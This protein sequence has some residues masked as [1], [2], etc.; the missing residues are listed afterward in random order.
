MSLWQSIRNQVPADVFVPVDDTTV[1]HALATEIARVAVSVSGA[2]LTLIVDAATAEEVAQIEAVSSNA[3]SVY[4]FGEPPAAWKSLAQI[5]TLAPSAGLAAGD[6]FL[7]M[8]SSR[9]SQALLGEEQIVAAETPLNGG[10]TGQRPHVHAIAEAILAAGRH[11]HPLPA[12]QLDPQ[13]VNIGSAMTMH[14]LGVL[15]QQLAILHQ[16]IARDKHDLFSVLE[17]LKAIS[18]K[19]RAHDV[20]FVFV[21]RISRVVE[22]DRCSVV[23]V[24][25]GENKGTVLASHEDESVRDLVIDLQKYPEL[26]RA[27]ETRERLLIND[28][29]RDPLTRDMADELRGAGVKV[30]LVVPIVL[31]DPN[32]GTLLLRITRA[33][34]AFTMREIGFCEIVAEAAAN[35]LERAQLFESIQQA[36]ERLER[37]AIT[38][39]LT[40]L[41]NRR[42]FHERLEEEF[43]RA[44]RYSLPLSCMI[45]DID[46][47]KKINDTY[48][49]LQGDAILREIGL[50]TAKVTRKSDVTARYGGEEFVVIMPQTDLEGA[51]AQA[52]RLRRELGNHVYP[53]MPPGEN[54]T[55]SVGVA[56]L[57]HKAI[58]DCET[59][60]SI[61]DAA[62]Y[63]AKRG[64]K[65]RVVI[66]KS[67]GGGPK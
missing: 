65:N 28:V 63:E 16:D 39:A 56:V 60:I 66:G 10:W 29:A 32:V 22:T 47:F 61:A 51:E 24:W 36:N 59:L 7:V 25:G 46:N 14:L 33:R 31:F 18:A 12:P 5:T 44:R 64:G 8:L 48:G 57:D 17:I 23:R 62:L 19:R 67:E 42:H 43:H 45:F 38:D 58:L 41:H 15:A 35:A 13:A 11:K 30:L 6:R 55:V 1:F 3:A 50:C 9:L 40:G 4:I 20:L 52:E 2:E 27:M 49:H 21:D 37:L 53:G 54:V 34:R 26:M